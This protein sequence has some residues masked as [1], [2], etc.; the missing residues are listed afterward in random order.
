MGDGGKDAQQYFIFVKYP[1]KN[2]MKNN[3]KGVH[4]TTGFPSNK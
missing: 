1:S 3:S 2:I 4:K